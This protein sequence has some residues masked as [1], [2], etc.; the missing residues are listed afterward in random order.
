MRSVLDNAVEYRSR[1]GDP[2]EIVVVGACNVGKSTVL[3]AI[4]AAIGQPSVSMKRNKS[5]RDKMGRP[6]ARRQAR[7]QLLT[8]SSTAGATLRPVQ[9]ES[10]SAA[11]N[12][13]VESDRHWIGRWLDTPGQIH[14]GHV[15]NAARLRLSDSRQLAPT[16]PLRAVTTKIE[17]GQALIL[18]G[19]GTVAQL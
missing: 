11:S 10:V 1:S 13:S 18:G 12:S 16:K 3:N 8:V 7:G 5:K 2:A 4:A 9:F 6:A 15:A 17:A 19:V 14:S